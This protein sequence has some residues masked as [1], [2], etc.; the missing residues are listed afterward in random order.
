MHALIAGMGSLVQKKN[1]VATVDEYLALRRSISDSLTVLQSSCT[2]SGP[3][4]DELHKWLLPYLSLCDTAMAVQDLPAAKKE[5]EKQ[6]YFFILYN[7][8][9]EQDQ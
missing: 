6:E 5:M 9:F 8:Y 3:A 4:H 1:T 7:R 2:M